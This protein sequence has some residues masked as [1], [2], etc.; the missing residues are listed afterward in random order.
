MLTYPRS[1]LDYFTFNNKKEKKFNEY[2]YISKLKI[3]TFDYDAWL[4]CN[5]QDLLYKFHTLK[6]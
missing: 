3:G 2:Y 1:S 6:M 5:Q 4:N